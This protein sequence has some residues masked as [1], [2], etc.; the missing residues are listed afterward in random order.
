M[1]KDKKTSIEIERP[2]IREIE[3]DTPHPKIN[4]DDEFKAIVNEN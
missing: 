2:T 1:K 3:T 4:D